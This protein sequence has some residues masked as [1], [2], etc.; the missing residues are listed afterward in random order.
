MI[1]GGCNE[2]QSST[3]F[4]K[5]RHFELV[6]TPPPLPEQKRKIYSSTWDSNMLGCSLWGLNPSLNRLNQDRKKGKKSTSERSLNVILTSR[7][8]SLRVKTAIH[9]VLSFVRCC[10][11]LEYEGLSLIIDTSLGVLNTG[12]NITKYSTTFSLFPT[13][14]VFPLHLLKAEIF[15]FAQCSKRQ[16]KCQ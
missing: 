13:S 14:S 2:N 15:Y 1:Y 4:H 7:S 11:L 8:T 6:T 9:C 10:T 12:R 5:R 3:C 16:E